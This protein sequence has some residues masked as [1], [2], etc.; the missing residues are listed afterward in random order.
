VAIR[1]SRNA[2]GADASGIYP[3]GAS[4]V[5]FTAADASGNIATCATGVTV[6]DTV[7]PLL[8][9]AGS[10]AQLWPPNHRLV[11]VTLS[12]QAT[13]L[14]TLA[15]TVRLL[16]ATSNEP[17]DAPGD[18]DGSTTGDV[19][20][21]DLGTADTQ[22][23]VRAERAATGTGRTCE[24][25]YEADDAAGNVSVG[26]VQI[27]VPHDMGIGAE[28][29]TLR[30]QPGE[31]AGSAWIFWD[32]VAGATGYDLIAG[33]LSN[34]KSKPNLLSLGQVT[35]LAAGTQATDFSESSGSPAPAVG[36]AWFY[37]LQYRQADGTAA[38]YGS[39]TAA[40][41]REPASCGGA[42]P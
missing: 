14:C 42:C 4:P 20:D 24:L 32:P 18:G 29:L 1:N 25:K 5:T 26:T 10:P 41:P 12:W 27:Q 8:T 34:V 9:V 31:T 37:L 21:A 2:S 28:P 3:L 19:S 36:K 6:R 13:D 39:V 7:P 30:L 16:S 17:D 35:V 33:D 23:S 38:G 11:P 15:P 22:V 40:L